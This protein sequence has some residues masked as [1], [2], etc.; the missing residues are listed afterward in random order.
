MVK[1]LHPG[2]EAWLNHRNREPRMDTILQ[3][4]MP[5]ASSR[6][7]DKKLKT[8]PY[9]QLSISTTQ[10]WES[11]GYF[12]KSKLHFIV[13]DILQTE[14]VSVIISVFRFGLLINIIWAEY[15]YFLQYCMCALLLLTQFHVK[16][17]ISPCIPRDWSVYSLSARRHFWTLFTYRV[18]F[19]DW[20]DCADAH[21]DLRL[22]WALSMRS[23]RKSSGPA[24]FFFFFF[25]FILFY[26]FFF[27]LF[28]FFLL[29]IHFFFLLLVFFV[30]V[31]LL[32][33]FFTKINA[34]IFIRSSFTSNDYPQHMFSL[35]HTSYLA[36]QLSF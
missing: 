5:Y 29:F 19:G 8:V 21:I 35:R 1:A 17:Q 33:L 16:T 6:G 15:H 26:F 18:F 31:F 9:V 11:I 22:C 28:F 2:Y 36:G 10:C 34:I 12:R 23:C 30:V 14:Y 13:A 4:Q 32:L 3:L 24:H 25:F 27:I 7:E 20:S